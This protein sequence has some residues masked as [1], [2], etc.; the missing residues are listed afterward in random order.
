MRMSTIDKYELIKKITADIKEAKET[1]AIPI[2]FLDGWIIRLEKQ[3]DTK[4]AAT[5]RRAIDSW[6]SHNG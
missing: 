5:L 1:E 4:Q 6:R 3:G 2:Y